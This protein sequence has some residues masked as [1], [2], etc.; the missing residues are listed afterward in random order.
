[1]KILLIDFYDSFTFNLKH[2]VESLH[3]S[4]DVV[5]HDEI[6]DLNVLKDYSHVILSPGPGM[7]EEKVNM[8]EIIEFCDGKIQLLGICLGMQAIGV[9]LGGKLE[10][11]SDVKHGVSEELISNR[12][13]LFNDLPER[14]F[15]GLYHSWTLVNINK[16]N[17]DARLV[18]NNFIM[19]LSDESRKLYGF[20]FHPESVL[21]QYGKELIANFLK[22]V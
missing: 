7:P 14:F 4:V 3:G 16:K 13:A 2:Y 21:S 6:N 20:Q 1:M 10:N 5:R 8:F 11:M 17:I 15:V 9:Y 22:Q 19:S 18:K 12:G